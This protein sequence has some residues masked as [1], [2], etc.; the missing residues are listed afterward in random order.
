V[1]GPAGTRILKDRL[2][3]QAEIYTT[4]SSVPAG[5]SLST[6][7]AFA[8]ITSRVD[9][10]YIRVRASASNSFTCIVY[11]KNTFADDDEVF[12]S[13][14][15]TDKCW[16]ETFRFYPGLLYHDEDESGKLHV[17][18]VNSDSVNASTFK[19]KILAE[20]ME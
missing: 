19:I 10:R 12:R 9:I 15:I 18:I 11:D 4:T 1:G 20:A 6:S 2:R 3:K 5:G 16:T 13:K 14:T 7:L 8:P 17:K